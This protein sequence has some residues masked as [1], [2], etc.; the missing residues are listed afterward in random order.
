MFFFYLKLHICRKTFNRLTNPITNQVLRFPKR[1]INI[2]S[3]LNNIDYITRAADGRPGPDRLRP[4][5]V[6][7]RPH[8]IPD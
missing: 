8:L 1:L 3:F 2:E 7:A 6:A 5:R 4:S